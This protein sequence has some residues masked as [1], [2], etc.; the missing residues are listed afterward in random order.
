MGYDRTY[1]LTDGQP[2]LGNHQKSPWKKSF[3]KK[4]PKISH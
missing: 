2:R 3:R 1:K 4:S